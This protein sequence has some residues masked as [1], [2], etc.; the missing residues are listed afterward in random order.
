MRHQLSSRICNGKKIFMEKIFFFYS[1]IFQ[2]EYAM[3]SLQQ[4]LQKLNDN[5][6]N[7]LDK[8]KSV[9]EEAVTNHCSDH[10]KKQ[11]LTKVQT[12]WVKHQKLANKELK[13][14]LTSY[15]DIG[16]Y[17]LRV[18]IAILE[19]LQVRI[20]IRNSFLFVYHR[21]LLIN[22]LVMIM[23]QIMVYQILM[24]RVF[25][26]DEILILCYVL[27]LIQHR[28]IHLHYLEL[29][30]QNF[31]I[32]IWHF[33]V[34]LYSFNVRFSY[35]GLFSDSLYSPEITE[36]AARSN[37]PSIG[38]RNPPIILQYPSMI[39]SPNEHESTP[40][41]PQNGRFQNQISKLN[42]LLLN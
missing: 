3:N 34:N 25:K 15:C 19:K 31:W 42:D 6:S 11:L 1:K 28:M 39:N 16:L 41:T 30:D 22:Y 37:L 21:L 27:C 33:Q 32:I 12:E 4:S 14:G 24:L 40:L 13:Q 9:L 18:Q 2:I 36:A 38:Q 5:I 26:L 23:I 8:T 7:D 29:N 17:N 20:S 35:L 10:T